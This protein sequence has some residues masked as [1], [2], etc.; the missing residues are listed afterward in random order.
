M[1]PGARAPRRS[2]DGTSFHPGPGSCAWVS[3]RAFHDGTIARSRRGRDTAAADALRGASGS[4]TGMRPIAVRFAGKKGSSVEV[5]IDVAG[6]SVRAS[7]PR[8]ARDAPP[9]LV[10][11]AR[12]QADD[13]G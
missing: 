10:A 11:G 5:G 12:S 2:R 8:R 9:A 3:C 13:D 4:V 6:G 7:D 1:R